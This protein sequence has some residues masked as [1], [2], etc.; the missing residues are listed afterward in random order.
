M[1]MRIIV[2]RVTAIYSGRGETVLPMGKRAVIIKDDN[3]VSIHNDKSIKPLNYMKEAVIQE[4]INDN[5][6]KVL[7]FDAN[8]EYLQVTLHEVYSEFSSVLMN[9]NEPG[10]ERDG[11]EN[12]LQEWL[13]NN[14]WVFGENYTSIA[15]EY[16]TGNGPVD[17]LI[18]TPEGI[19]IAVEVK[20]TAT[21]NAIDQVRRYVEALKTH[22]DEELP[23][24]DFTKT[25]GIVT[26]LDIRPKVYTMKTTSTKKIQKV[27]I[28]DN[29][30]TIKKLQE[31]LENNVSPEETSTIIKPLHKK[32]EKIDF[33]SFKDNEI[34]LLLQ[35]EL[36]Y[37]YHFIKEKNEPL[38]FSANDE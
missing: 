23:G 16:A 12:H 28:P 19:P 5:G 31:K 11:T 14:P 29:W 6:E 17:L 4:S 36:E 1:S 32:L 10:L 18:T 13:Y 34:V 38:N 20:R 15:R 25:Q 21:M 9:N 7:L 27:V 35:Q 3:S 26:A 30:K 8:R 24:T 33:S 22:T 2:A 37:A